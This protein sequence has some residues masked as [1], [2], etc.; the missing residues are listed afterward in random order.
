M[1]SASGTVL[2]YLAVFFVHRISRSVY[3]LYHVQTSRNELSTMHIYVLL[4]FRPPTS[5]SRNRTFEV[6]T[7]VMA[8][9]FLQVRNVLLS[10][11][12]TNPANLL[13]LI[14]RAISKINQEQA[15]IEICWI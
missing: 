12:I 2:C 8:V 14:R 10:V 11:P 13:D 6:V 3:R 5:P 4:S 9:R 15:T 1:H 7:F